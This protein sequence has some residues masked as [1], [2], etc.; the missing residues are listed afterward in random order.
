MK[1]GAISGYGETS[2]L[3]LDR[4]KGCHIQVREW[5]LKVSAKNFIF[6]TSPSSWFSSFTQQ[7]E[8]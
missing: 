7:L 5:S 6:S 4:N 1:Q 2:T 3:V 8:L